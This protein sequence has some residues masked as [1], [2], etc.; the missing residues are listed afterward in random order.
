MGI[1]I[2]CFSWL[3][4]GE[5]EERLRY[6]LTPTFS[7]SLPVKACSLHPH[8]PKGTHSMDKQRAQVSRAVNL[9]SFTAL[10]WSKIL[11]TIIHILYEAFSLALHQSLTSFGH[12]IVSKESLHFY[13]KVLSLLYATET[14][15]SLK[16]LKKIH[17]VK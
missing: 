7:P 5:L 6:P 3:P 9:T 17:F 12:D 2:G 10:N 15:F 16:C 11:K 1:F 13:H 4:W 8:T 14:F